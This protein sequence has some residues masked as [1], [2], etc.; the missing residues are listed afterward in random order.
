MQHMDELSSPARRS[1]TRYPRT[2]RTVTVRL[3]P[4]VV[5]YMERVAASNGWSLSLVVRD[6]TNRW[7]RREIRAQQRARATK[8][9]EQA[10]V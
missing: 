10:S 1:G 7:T 5:D 6:A 3:D 4:R 8:G 9:P 2:L